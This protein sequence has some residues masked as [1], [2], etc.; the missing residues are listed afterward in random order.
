MS[1]FLHPYGLSFVQLL[2]PSLVL[3]VDPGR[4]RRWQACYVYRTAQEEGKEG[5]VSRRELLSEVFS[6]TGGPRERLKV[7]AECMEAAGKPSVVVGPNMVVTPKDP[8]TEGRPQ[9]F[10]ICFDLDE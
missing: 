3:A 6:P 9:V 5:A 10:R 4:E 7:L 2:S 8:T 1:A